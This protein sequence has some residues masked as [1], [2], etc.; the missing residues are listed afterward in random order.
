MAKY[1]VAGGTGGNG[2][3][4]GKGGAVSLDIIGGKAG[5]PDS[6]KLDFPTTQVDGPIRFVVADV[7]MMRLDP[8]GKIYIRGEHTGVNLEAYNTFV[9]W[10]AKSKITLEPGEDGVA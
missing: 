2:N 4:P 9:E 6:T 10:L 7:E 3:P 5:K 8:D 1:T